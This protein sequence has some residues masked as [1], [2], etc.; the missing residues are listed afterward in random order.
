MLNKTFFPSSNKIAAVSEKFSR[1]SLSR[2]TAEGHRGDVSGRA[3]QESPKPDDAML[4][5]WRD[6]RIALEQK[7]QQVSTMLLLLTLRA[8][9]K[10]SISLALSC[11]V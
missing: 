9:S 2:E 10:P 8:H 7:R 3:R 1:Q 5:Q 4:K 6:K 11:R